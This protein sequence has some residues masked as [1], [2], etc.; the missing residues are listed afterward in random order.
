MCNRKHRAR[1]PGR[2]Q[3]GEESAAW[4]ISRAF[5]FIIRYWPADIICR[6]CASVPRDTAASAAF[7]ATLPMPDAVSAA[8]HSRNSTLRCGASGKPNAVHRSEEHTSELQSLRHL[9][10]RLLL[11]K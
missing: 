9:V 1:L 7:E 4:L 6:R 3:I 11:E 2:S 10:C 8:S 5:C